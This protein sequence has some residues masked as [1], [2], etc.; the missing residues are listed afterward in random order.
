MKPFAG[1]EAKKR[2]RREILPAGGYVVKILDASE[3][4]YTWGN[5]LEI[6]F[7]VLEGERKDFFRQDYKSNPNEDKK[8]RGK[9][10]L[11]VPKEDGTEQ[12]SWTINTFNGVMYA[13]EESNLGFHWDWNEAKLKG[14]TVGAL[15]RNREWEMNGR[16]GWTTEC[17]A[18]IE[19]EEV[20]KG[21]FQIPEDR[22]LAKKQTA[23]APVQAVSFEEIEDDDMPF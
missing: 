16:T 5:V 1:Y 15:F 23:S 4:S 3:Q 21:A 12:D 8:W 13:L 2:A 19:A 11:N 9:Y 20:R 14:L 10:R 7:D 17:C 6:S 22:P 18:L